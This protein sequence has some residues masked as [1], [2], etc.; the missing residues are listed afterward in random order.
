MRLRSTMGRKST[1]SHIM[2]CAAEASEVCSAA[3][4]GLRTIAFSILCPSAR[5]S[6]S[7]RPIIPITRFHSSVTG[8]RCSPVSSEICRSSPTVLEIFNVIIRGLLSTIS[9]T[10]IIFFLINL[11]K[12]ARLIIDATVNV[13]CLDE[14]MGRSSSSANAFTSR[15]VPK[16]PVTRTPAP[17]SSAKE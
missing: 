7:R 9:S 3:V 10:S 4:T 2:I 12:I 11:S 1:P 16:P 14:M 8:K 6:T 13:S 17:C 5:S 15:L